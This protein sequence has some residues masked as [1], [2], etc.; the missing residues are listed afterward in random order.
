MS[1][2]ALKSDEPGA[3]PVA[4]HTPMMAQY[5]ALKS[6]YPDALLFYRMGD[7]YELFFDDAVTASAC[8]DIT[9]TARGKNQGEEIPMCGVPFHSYEPYLAKL[10]R[11]G[12][13]VAIC[14]QTETPERAK[15][16]GGSKA[17]VARDVVRLVTQGTLT[18]DNLLNARDNNY[19]AALHEVGGQFAMSWMDLS[20]GEFNVQ[21]LQR[22]QVAAALERIAPAEL[23]LHDRAGSNELF[24]PFSHLISPQPASVFDPQKTRRHLERVVGDAATGLESLSRAKLAATG[25][26]VDYATRAYKGRLPHITSLRE[27]TYAGTMEIDP[28]TRRSLELTRTQS[29]ERRGSLLDA[30]DR[31]ITCPGARLLQAR[32]ASPLTDIAE[33]KGRHDGVEWFLANATQREV[34]RE[35]LRGMPD[36]ERAIA[37][38]TL[39][40]GGPRDLGVVR[41][42]A[43]IGE[44][45]R[46][47]LLQE[48]DKP[49]L[50][51]ACALEV[52]AAVLTLKDRLC[53]ALGETLPVLERDGGFVKPDYAPDLD[54]LRGLRDESKRAI[55][56]LQAKYRDDTGISLLKISYNNILGYYIEVPARQAD[57]LLGAASPGGISY[58]HRQSLLNA[59]RFTT[60]E[61]NELERDIASSADK[62]LAIE[63][64]IFAEFVQETLA[65]SGPLSRLAQ[66]LAAL[67][68]AMALAELASERSYARPVIDDSSEFNITGGRHPVVEAALRKSGE[69]FIANDCDLGQGHS[70]WLLTGPNMAGKSTFLRQN[71]LI[72]IL[73]QIGSFVPA[74]SA[75]IGVVDKCFSRVGASDDLARGRSTF[76]VEMVETAAILKNATPR[77]LVILDEIGRGTATYDGLSI[78]W[79]CVEHLHEVNR[80]RA[81]FATHYHELTSLKSKL[82]ALSCHSMAVKE[83]Q[84]D[85]I[86]L[87]S[88]QNGAADRSYG[89]HVAKLA[90]LPEAVTAR[91]GEV[92]ALLSKGEHSGAVTRLADDLPLFQAAP[93]AAIPAPPSAVDTELASIEPDLLTPR[94]AL[95][96]IY[97]LKNLS[98]NK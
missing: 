60:S 84:G 68:V 26:I 94:E 31:T 21:E 70:L 61:L 44:T 6:Q 27:I 62:A 81:I 77:S 97:R 76:M 46:A 3:A 5:H 32:L 41:D 95:D 93:P 91:A 59:A 48:H 28:A 39:G 37:R 29:G 1:Q 64:R 13:K 33:I 34:L 4:T 54:H 17:L 65:Q 52:P 10:I 18:E 24:K 9:L 47:L 73:A 19:L 72:A 25:A 8:L 83:W 96:I 14:E 20:T 89:I 38:L 87:H 98:S 86:F 74:A 69:A 58:I 78:A 43:A 7:F 85:V 88:V 51:F 15:Q 16:R 35:K 36:L 30:I 57:R 55:A 75:R 82:P 50:D 56:A 23:L 71:A 42:A 67:D 49:A 90:G 92:L 79:A 80:C 11:S 2:S 63:L 40:R 12:H 45:M 66:A 22:D 53:S